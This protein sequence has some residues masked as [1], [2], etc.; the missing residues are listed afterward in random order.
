MIIF[1][2]SKILSKTLAHIKQIS[3]INVVMYILFCTKLVFSNRSHTVAAASGGCFKELDVL[4]AIYMQTSPGI[5]P[6]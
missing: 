6:D 1:E 4:E 3:N 5:P 2:G